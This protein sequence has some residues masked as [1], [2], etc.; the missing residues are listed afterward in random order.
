MLN[1]IEI[2]STSFRQDALPKHGL[3]EFL[4]KNNN[5]GTEL[6]PNPKNLG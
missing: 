4:P 2:F 1:F 5:F 3:G 6:N